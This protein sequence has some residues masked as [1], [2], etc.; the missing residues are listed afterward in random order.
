MGPWV[1]ELKRVVEEQPD[2]RGVTIDLRG[3]TFADGTGVSLLRALRG[4]GTKLVGWSGFIGALIGTEQPDRGGKD[5][6]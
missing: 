5:V 4:V 6:G 2:S 1:D 3:L